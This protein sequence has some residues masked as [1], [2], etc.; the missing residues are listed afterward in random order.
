MA[1]FITLLKFTPQGLT[2]VHD[3]GKRAAAFRTT[4]KKLGAKV[5]AAYWTLGA[6]DGV[7]IFEAPDDETATALML[8][9]ASQGFVQTQTARAFTAT[10]MEKV[11]AAGAGAR[12]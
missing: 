10:E 2:Y 3:T 11:L 9:L 12:A 1:T 8:D 4:A 7:V 6:F 5:T